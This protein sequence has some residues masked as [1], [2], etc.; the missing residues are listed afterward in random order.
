[1]KLSEY[2]KKNNIGYDAAYKRFRLGQIPNSYKTETGA[3]FIKEEDTSWKDELI[4]LQKEKI[5]QLESKLK[6]LINKNI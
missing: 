2:A 1:M 3:I 5:E 4:K 6:E